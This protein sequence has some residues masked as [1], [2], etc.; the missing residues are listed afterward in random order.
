[1][2]VQGT[3]LTLDRVLVEHGHLMDWEY[4]DGNTKYGARDDYSWYGGQS[5]Q[6]KSYSLWYNNKN[7]VMGRLFAWDLG[8]DTLITDEEMVAQGFAYQW[9]PAGITITP[10]ID[11]L[12]PFDPVAPLPAKEGGVM[13]YKVDAN[14]KMGITNPWA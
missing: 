6:F 12:H 10:H 13:A 4:F 11:V 7:A 5:R 8:N 9:V 2:E 14:D 3:S 1:M